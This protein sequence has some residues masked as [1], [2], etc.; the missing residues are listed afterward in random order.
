MH[1]SA[2]SNTN[3]NYNTGM[4]FGNI[5][6]AVLKNMDKLPVR[7]RKCLEKYMDV[8]NKSEVVDLFLTKENKLALLTKKPLKMRYNDE[9][10]F[11]DNA[12]KILPEGSVIEFD[13][14]IKK[15]GKGFYL[16]KT[17]NIASIYDKFLSRQHAH[18]GLEFGRIKG[19]VGMAEKIL[20][21]DVNVDGMPALGALMDMAYHLEEPLQKIKQK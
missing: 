20:D 6:T 5:D 16:G 9:N 10:T 14:S 11:P 19:I 3:R 12:I 13:N 8:L 18:I 21:D 7:S 15:L 4:S 2:I 1:I 17:T